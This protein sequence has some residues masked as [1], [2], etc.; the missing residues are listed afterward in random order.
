MA[1]FKKNPNEVYYPEGKK[2][3]LSIIK[4]ESGPTD[5]LWK[6][7]YEDFNEGSKLIVGENQEALFYKN[8][9]IEEIFTAGEYTLSTQNYP[10]ISRL[11]NSLSGGVSA[12]NCKVYYVNENQ[13]MNLRW[14]TD[15]PVQ[16]RDP[17][18]DLATSVISRGAYTIAV[19][20]A[21]QFFLK[22]VGNNEERIDTSDIPIKF[23]APINQTIKSSLG[24]VIRDMDDEILGICDRQMEVAEA[25][26]PYL[27]AVFGEYGLRLI[28]FYVE[29][30]E[31][32]D[33]ESR[34]VLEAA[35]AARAATII[36]AQGERA[37][38]DTLGITYQTERTYDVLQ[39]AAENEGAGLTAMMA[40]AGAGL[41]YGG[42]I[43]NM[44]ANNLTPVQNQQVAGGPAPQF[45]RMQSSDVSMQMSGHVA[46]APQPTGGNFCTDC[47]A[48]VPAGSKFCPGCGKSMQILC[49]DCSSPVARGSKF[50]P[51]CGKKLVR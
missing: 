37:R 20:N 22:Y 15:G 48:D 18:F 30:I 39:G 13:N 44:A 26:K 47:G 6:V 23:R 9:V 21:K 50:C 27:E 7:P 42:A 24:K 10:F 51:E 36:T 32:A 49:P 34:K 12:F 38:L 19:V 33:N 25:Q 14:G 5:I 8:G 3:F 4:N 46:P 41:V 29:A 31:I 17:R 35:R 43:G 45:Q 28:D 2:T 11:K 1:L 16:V 40:G